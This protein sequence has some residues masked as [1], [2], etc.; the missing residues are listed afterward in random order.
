[1]PDTRGRFFTDVPT[2]AGLLLR[3]APQWGRIQ[4]TGPADQRFGADVMDEVFN[5]SPIATDLSLRIRRALDSC[6]INVCWISDWARP[7]SG[8]GD[9]E[10]VLPIS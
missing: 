9:Y 4:G 2:S 7:K 5:L 8:A 1:V 6:R 10:R 3:T